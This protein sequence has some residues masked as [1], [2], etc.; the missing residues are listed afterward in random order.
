MHGRIGTIHCLL[1]ITRDGRM[2]AAAVIA[3]ICLQDPRFAPVQALLAAAPA[4]APA[5][6]NFANS[7]VSCFSTWHAVPHAATKSRILGSCVKECVP[8]RSALQLDGI[9]AA[10]EQEDSTSVFGLAG[11]LLERA[12]EEGRLAPAALAPPALAPAALAPP[13][14]APAPVSVTRASPAQTSGAAAAPG[15]VQ[16]AKPAKQAAAVSK[17]DGLRLMLRHAAVEQVSAG[18]GPHPVLFVVFVVCVA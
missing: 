18:T 9:A 14:L 10:D 2:R 8:N 13:A 4:D 12:L 5:R 16:L 11:L 1:P 15:S 7:L 6:R 17:Y 3:P